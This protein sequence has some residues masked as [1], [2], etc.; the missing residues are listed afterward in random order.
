MAAWL[1][2]V[3]WW[4]SVF[5]WLGALASWFQ[6]V[7]VLGLG[8]EEI[9]MHEWKFVVVVFLWIIITCSYFNAMFTIAQPIPKEYHIKAVDDEVERNRRIQRKAES[10][11]VFTVNYC[12]TCHCVKPLRAHHCKMCR[13]CVLRMDHH[14][15]LLQVCVHHHNHKFFLLFLL[16][17]CSLGVYVTLITI[18]FVIRTAQDL[19]NG[20][21][22]SSEHHLLNSA[23]MN[24]VVIAI[25]VG[26]LLKTQMQSLFLNRTTIE[27]SQLSFI[28]EDEM[29]HEFSIFDL[30]TRL[31]NFCSIFGPRPATWFLPV[32][33]TPGDGV[34]YRYTVR[35]G[36]EVVSHTGP[37][38][39]KRFYEI[40]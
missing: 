3:K 20:G 27:D 40:C 32:Y 2:S 22:L 5:G 10:L 24:A 39:K 33:S 31:E 18:P 35:C 15:P 26:S 11:N 9:M 14:C 12:E 36:K 21:T 38:R 19:W 37:P 4:T 7:V 16:W 25:S 1:Q 23:I 29:N 13:R 8:R 6:I 34:N 30:G 17:P 28:D